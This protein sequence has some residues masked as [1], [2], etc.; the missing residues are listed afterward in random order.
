MPAQMTDDELI[1]KTFLREAW[2]PSPE[3][4]RELFE[5]E[6]AIML[7]PSADTLSKRFQEARAEGSQA[8]RMVQ[9]LS[10]K[11]RNNGEDAARAWL[12]SKEGS[13]SSRIFGHLK[14]HFKNQSAYWRARNDPRNQPDTGSRVRTSLIDGQYHPNSLRRLAPAAG[15]SIYID[16]TGRVFEAIATIV[17]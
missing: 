7:R 2:G 15:W 1:W 5:L 14:I 12:A 4:T 11:F 10:S 8:F 13:A 17:I 3:G 9:D 6:S 16:E